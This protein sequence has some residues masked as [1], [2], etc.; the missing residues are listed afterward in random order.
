MSSIRTLVV[1]G[2]LLALAA[3]GTASTDLR[4]DA[5]KKGQF[6]VDVPF[7][8]AYQNFRTLASECWERKYATTDFYVNVTKKT[9]KTATVEIMW[10]QEFRTLIVL[11]ADIAAATGGTDVTYFLDDKRLVFKDG[12]TSL[13]DWARGRI[14][15][16]GKPGGMTLPHFDLDLGLG[17]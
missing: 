13:T 11:S 15:D 6:H 4:A 1:L 17:L 12:Q 8:L 5:G 7:E 10:E 3:C 2:A 14:D 16:C 9:E